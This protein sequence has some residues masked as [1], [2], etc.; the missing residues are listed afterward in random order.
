MKNI[1]LSIFLIIFTITTYAHSGKARYHT[2]VDTDCAADDLRT[3][4]MI[5]ASP[6]FEVLA[7]TTSDGILKPKE[8]YVKV[9]SLLNDFGHQGIPVSY[10]ETNSSEK[11]ACYELNR[12]VSWGN[13]N[14]VRLPESEGAKELIRKSIVG[15]DEKVLL[16]CLG[17]L[18]NIV[19]VLKDKDLV[20][21]IEKIVWYCDDYSDG[22]GFNFLM[23]INAA[24]VFKNADVEKVVIS[25]NDSDDFIL[26]DD[27]LEVISKQTNK[28]A[29]KIYT[30]HI[31]QRYAEAVAESKLKFWDDL[32]PAYL[33]YPQFFIEQNDDSNTSLVI[34]K[35]ENVKDVMRCLSEILNSKTSKECKVFNVFP[36]DN[37]LYADDVSEN[38]TEI[39]AKHGLTEW[40]AG[41]LTNE[42]H[43]HLGIYAIVGVKMGIR[44]REYFNIGVDDIYITSF[45]GNYPPTSCMND[46]L[47]V[48]TGATIGHGLIAISDE[49]LKRPEAIFKFKSQKVKLRLKDEYWNLIRSD[50]KQAI[51]EHGKLTPDYWVQIRKLAIRYWEEFDRMEMFEISVVE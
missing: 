31:D 35:T 2:I 12:A 21:Q 14:G 22:K 47:Q 26:G 30:T 9:S 49:E 13:S 37:G 29:G 19:D 18:T 45:A 38:M 16:I 8:G 44:V 24:K 32:I 36:L 51:A 20:S 1:F 43:G 34:P 5:L 6:E 15:E 33:L 41:V 25:N 10:G 48:S 4:C 28:Y 40:R 23:D 7:I 17:P 50:V 3:L 11:P 39:I 42:L 46:G 27:F